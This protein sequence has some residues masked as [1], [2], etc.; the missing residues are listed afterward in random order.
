MITVFKNYLRNNIEEMTKVVTVIRA[1]IE[2][3]YVN[4][5]KKSNNYKK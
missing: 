4:D 2:I 1:I 3:V 5:N